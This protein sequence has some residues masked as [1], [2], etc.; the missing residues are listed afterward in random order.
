MSI[1]GAKLLRFDSIR[2]I[3]C[4]SNLVK[5]NRFESFTGNLNSWDRSIAGA[6]LLRSTRCESNLVKSNRFTGSRYSWYMS[7]GGVNLFRFEFEWF[8]WKSIFR[9][10]EYGGVKL[11]RFESIRSIRCDSNLVKSNR[12]TGSRYSWYMSIG[13][14]V[15]AI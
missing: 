4:E 6:K 9:F 3:R 10:Y 8:H 14:E 2:S 11:L 5:S 13:G 12:F 1:A 15:I 7:I